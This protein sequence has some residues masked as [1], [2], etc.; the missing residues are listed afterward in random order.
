MPEEK[1][2]ARKVVATNRV[3]RHEY[4]IAEVIEAGMV[5]QGTEVKSLR[6]GKANLRD[7]YARIENGDVMLY[8]MHIAPYEHGNRWNHEPTRPRRLLLRRDEIRRLYGKVRT[9]GFTLVPLSAYFGPRGHVKLELA[10]AQGKK[11]WDKR[12][13]MAKRD[14]Q[15][16][17]ARAERKRES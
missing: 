12:D 2:S 10:L 4:H 16:E 6:S 14:M 7:S 15:L 1:A 3:A 17:I 9:Q 5:L 13:D 8:N 11:L